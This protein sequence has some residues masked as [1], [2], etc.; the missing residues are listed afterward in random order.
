MDYP[1]VSSKN[2]VPRYMRKKLNLI[3]QQLGFDVEAMR[4]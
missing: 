4:A 2:K 1:R 3:A